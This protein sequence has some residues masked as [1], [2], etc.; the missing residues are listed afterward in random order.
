MLSVGNSN[1]NSLQ[2]SANKRFHHGLTVLA[3]YTWSKSIDEGSGDGSAP[4]N[5]FNIRAERGVSDFDIPQRFV[6]SFIWD[7]PR[8]TTH[9]ALIRQIASGWEVN[10]I[11]TAQ[12]GSPFSVTSGVDNS[13]SGVNADRANVVGSPSLSGS[14]SES[15]VLHQYFNTAAFTVNTLGTFGNSGRNILVGPGVVNLDFGAIKNFNITERYKVQFRAESFNLAN[16]PNFAN[17]NGN[18]SSTTFGTITA[19]AATA[20]GSPRVLQL[21]LK[22]IF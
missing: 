1:Y 16:H 4:A 9:G 3:N 22:L 5:P 20:A 14:R 7:L 19:T 6:A 21:A 17:P 15:Q 8:V 11:F 18:V 2:I 10:G 13:Q 12:S